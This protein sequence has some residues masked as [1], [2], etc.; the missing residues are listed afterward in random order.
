MQLNDTH[1]KHQHIYRVEWEPPHHNG[2][3][4]YLKWYSDGEFVFSILGESLSVM[5]T[6]IPSEPMYLMMNTAVSSKWGFPA[7]CPENCKCDCFECGDPSCS[8]ALPAKYCDNFPASFEI[9]YVRVYQ[10]V[11][12][13]KHILGCSPESRPTAKFI[14]GH[15]KRFM[16]EGDRQPLLDVQSGGGTCVKGKDCGGR[17]RGQCESGYCVCSSNTTGPFCLSHFGFYDHD[18]SKPTLPFS[19]KYHTPSDGILTI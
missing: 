9:D 4:G 12:D 6:E 19:C 16:V 1:F 17:E 2:T 18:T 11:D 3:G 10:A 8:C 15:Q 13:S 14:A 5:G 7:P